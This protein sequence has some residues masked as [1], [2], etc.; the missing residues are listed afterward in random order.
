MLSNLLNHFFLPGAGAFIP[1]AEA[2]LLANRVL[3]PFANGFEGSNF[4]LSTN[5]LYSAVS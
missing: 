4:V 1:A 2:V 5:G 3:A